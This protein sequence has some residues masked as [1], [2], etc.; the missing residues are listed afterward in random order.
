MCVWPVQP[1]N[2]RAL[3]WAIR[4]DTNEPFLF[5]ITAHIG[6]STMRLFLLSEI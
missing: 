4:P 6:S 1:D 3:S 5:L 2:W